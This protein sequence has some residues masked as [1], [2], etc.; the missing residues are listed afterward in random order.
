MVQ[1]ISGRWC[2]RVL[3]TL[4][5]MCLN[6][7]MPVEEEDPRRHRCH[8]SEVIARSG[9]CLIVVEEA[10]TEVMVVEVVAMQLVE[11]EDVEVEVVA[12]TTQLGEE[13]DVEVEVI[14]VA[15]QLVEEEDAELVE[16]N[17]I[18]V[19]EMEAGT[20][21]KKRRCASMALKRNTEVPWERMSEGQ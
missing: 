12:V 18:I 14:A 5:L 11:E 7:R 2:A 13:E 1:V 17:T 9:P 19:A 4:P 16:A 6:R 20:E 21:G 10:D 15:M 3:A 8:G